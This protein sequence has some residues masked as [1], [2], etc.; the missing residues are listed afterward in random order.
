MENEN[1]EKRII[2][3]QQKPLETN[4]PKEFIDTE[5]LEKNTLKYPYEF[6]HFYDLFGENTGK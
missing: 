3:G 6:Y 5:F 2:V 1:Q 4:V